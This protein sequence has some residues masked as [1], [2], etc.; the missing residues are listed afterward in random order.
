MTAFA[1]C[2]RR[3]PT[4]P[5]FPPVF[6]RGLRFLNCWEAN[7]A[8]REK[9]EPPSLHSGGLESE[10]GS[11]TRSTMRYARRRNLATPRTARPERAIASVDGSG[12]APELGTIPA[13]CVVVVPSTLYPWMC[14]TA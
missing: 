9:T 12:A 4:K 3:F 1:R 8:L 2:V 14:A 6:S 7:A 11:V 13:L 10:P 5:L